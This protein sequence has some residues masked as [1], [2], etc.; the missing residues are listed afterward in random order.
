MKTMTN[1][2]RCSTATR[3]SKQVSTPLDS[4]AFLH[5]FLSFHA[6]SSLVPPLGDPFEEQF[7]KTKQVFSEYIGKLNKVEDDKDFPYFN[8]AFTAIKPNDTVSPAS[9]HLPSTQSDH[10]L[11]FTL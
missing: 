11:T 9:S 7:N 8:D 1:M 10:S 5:L 4:P 2:S 6:L 3:T